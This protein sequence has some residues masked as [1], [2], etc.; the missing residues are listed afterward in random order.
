ML[1]NIK[2]RTKILFLVL[3]LMVGIGYYIYYAF[4]TVEEV[5][6][7][8]EIY[9]NIV[10][11]KDLIADILPPPEYIIESYLTVSQMTETT[12]SSEIDSLK[13]KMT[14]LQKDFATRHQYW[15]DNLEDGRQKDLITKESY[16]HALDFYEVYNTDFIDKINQKDVVAAKTILNTTM[17][18]HY[19]QHR[20]DIDELVKLAVAGAADYELKAEEIIKTDIRNLILIGVII[21]LVITLVLFIIAAGILRGLRQ[22]S[23]VSKDLAS[24]NG[25]LTIRLPDSNTDEIGMMS[26][27]FNSFLSKLNEIVRN[28][29]SSSHRVADETNQIKVSMMQISSSIEVLAHTSTT[30]AAS[31]EELSSTNIL[32]SEN[33]Q[34]LLSQAEETVDLAN[35]GGS[36]VKSTIDEMNRIKQVVNQG[37]TNVLNLGS[38]AKQIDEIV[39]VINDIASQTNLLALNAAIEAARAGDAGRGFEVVAEEVRKLAEKSAESTKEIA[40]MIKEIQSETSS[41]IEKMREVDE[42]VERGVK[43]ADRTGELLESIVVKMD[44]L[45]NLI[46]IIATSTKEQALA[47]EDMAKQT[48]S[49]TTNVEENSRAIDN[50]AHAIT[51]IARVADELSKI[52]NM[53]KV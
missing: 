10:L 18:D 19:N 53:F 31:I 32:V 4:A 46:H 47:T 17:K 29:R 41:A 36:A 1:G 23:D 21:A 14:V 51:E 52:V 50:S 22:I 42:E 34:H 24:G 20:T 28:L 2:I 7:K 38:K 11:Q 12:N 5:K 27:N 9:N 44:E 33:T 13:E 6:V 15:I 3:F 49:I 30:N 37:T 40:T 8:G 16:R 25:D 43:V 35:Q 45:K 39:I 48:E 26:R